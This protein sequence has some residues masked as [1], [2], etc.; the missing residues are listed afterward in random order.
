MQ[1]KTLKLVAIDSKHLLHYLMG[2]S[3]S[4]LKELYDKFYCCFDAFRQNNLS[5]AVIF[6]ENT[7]VTI[8]G[9]EK[10]FSVM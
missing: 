10:V 9:I 7:L 4:G 1:S 2:S 3:S 6:V 8:V 5:D